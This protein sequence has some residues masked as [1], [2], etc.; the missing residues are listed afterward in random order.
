MTLSE[1]IKGGRGRARELAVA[2]GIK[3]PTNAALIYQWAGGVRPV[4][5][6]RCPAIE[7]ATGGAVRCEELRPD[8]DWSA[9]RESV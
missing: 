3:D 9:V 6:E 2:L 4:P 1:F 8:V 7:R 5:A